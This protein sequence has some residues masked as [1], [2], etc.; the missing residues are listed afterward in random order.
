MNILNHTN[1]EPYSGSSFNVD[2][3]DGTVKLTFLNGDWIS[4]DSNYIDAF[5]RGLKD[6]TYDSILIGGLGLG[7]MSQWVKSNTSC[8]KI[9]VV[10]N[11][12]ELINWVSSSNYLDSS[13]NIIEGDILNYTTTS[14]YDLVLTD[15]W[16]VATN[17]YPEDKQKVITNLSGSLETSGS[18]YF[19]I[20][21]EFFS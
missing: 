16:W 14:S 17:T 18:M 7:L 20:A 2:Y 12:S 19:P 21:N 5:S 3:Q 6:L 4:D 9:D 11:N 1:I 8:S 10:E 15:K 13:I